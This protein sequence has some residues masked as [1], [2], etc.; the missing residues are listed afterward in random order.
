[1]SSTAVS[2]KFTTTDRLG[3]LGRG[4]G[5]ACWAVALVEAV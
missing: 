4:E 1:V 5:M 2:V 3:T